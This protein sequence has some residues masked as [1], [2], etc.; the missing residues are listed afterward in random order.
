MAGRKTH[1]EYGGRGSGRP[2][3]SIKYGKRLCHIVNDYPNPKEAKRKARLLEDDGILAVVRKW[4][5]RWVVY[6]CGARKRG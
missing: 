4:Y 2:P 6:R 3:D 5:S 1:I